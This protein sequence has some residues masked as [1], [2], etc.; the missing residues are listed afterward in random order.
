MVSSILRKF[1][2][3]IEELELCVCVLGVSSFY[4]VLGG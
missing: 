4:L 3:I 1:S 2:E